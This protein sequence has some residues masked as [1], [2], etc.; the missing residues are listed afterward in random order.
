MDVTVYFRQDWNLHALLPVCGKLRVQLQKGVFEMQKCIIE[1]RNDVT[2]IPEVGSS[3]S[4]KFL[5]NVQQ[6]SIWYKSQ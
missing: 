5:Y 1:T 6:C 3:L 2:P 4:C